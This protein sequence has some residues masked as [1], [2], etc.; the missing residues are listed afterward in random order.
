MIKLGFEPGDRASASLIS[1]C[2][3][4][5]KLEQAQRVFAALENFPT[6]GKLVYNSMIDAYVKCNKPEKAYSLYIE[7]TQ[8]GQELGA[9][10]VSMVVNSLSKN[11]ASHEDKL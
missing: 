3:R 11:G 9:V 7:V 1:L 2:G 8:K 4:K 6:T 5:Q 10:A